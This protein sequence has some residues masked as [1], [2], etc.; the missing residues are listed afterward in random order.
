MLVMAAVLMATVLILNRAGV[1]RIFSGEDSLPDDATLSKLNEVSRL[2]DQRYIDEAPKEEYGDGMVRG[3]VSTL[4]DPYA[5]YFSAEEYKEQLENVTRQ[6]YGIGTTLTQDAKTGRVTVVYVYRDTPAEAAGLKEGDEIL[7]V[8]GIQAR[9]VDLDELVAKIQGEE[10][11]NVEI[12]VSRDGVKDP[13]EMNMTCAVINL[14]TVDH[15]MLE[16]KIGYIMIVKFGSNTPEE[17]REAVEELEKQGMKGLILDI[18]YNGGGL[19]SSCVEILDSI[20]PG[21]TLV[22]TEDKYGQRKYE[23]SDDEHKLELPLAVLING[24]TASASEILAGAIRDYEWGTLIG[25]KTYG[26][27]VVQMTYGLGD[28]SAVKFTVEKYYTPN[29]ED[30]Q[31]VGIEPDVKL[32]YKF[33]GTKDDEY[34][35]SFDNQIRKGIEVLKADPSFEKGK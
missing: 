4:D 14:P 5:G 3:L 30:I 2:I 19:F 16:D 21:G 33:L 28:G 22:Y 25:T 24:E 8:N 18:R 34:D 1:I 12:T 31:D 26:K 10:G 32:E 9:S 35:W 29:G 15:K 11:T 7:S 6:Y 27:G 13:I 23:K 17:F 20:L